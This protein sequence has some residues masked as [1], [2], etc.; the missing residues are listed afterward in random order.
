[1]PFVVISAV[2][3]A[4]HT[5]VLDPVPN[6]FRRREF[7]RYRREILH[8]GSKLNFRSPARQASVPALFTLA[9]FTLTLPES[10]LP[11][12]AYLLMP[13]THLRACGNTKRPPPLA[14]ATTGVY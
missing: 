13:D 4:L 9:L 5:A 10:C 12:D 8:V 14:N 1:M 2:F 6:A 11:T 7:I 3:W